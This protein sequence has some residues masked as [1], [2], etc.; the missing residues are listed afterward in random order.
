MKIVY[1]TTIPPIASSV[2]NEGYPRKS[3]QIHL[4]KD[5]LK[6]DL[7]AKFWL[8]PKV[9]LAYNDGIDARSLRALTSIIERNRHRILK[10]WNEYFCSGY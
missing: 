3:A 2:C 7:E 9:R 6:D 1:R 4:K 5:D 8:Q 10:A